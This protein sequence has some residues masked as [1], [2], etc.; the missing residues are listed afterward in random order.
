MAKLVSPLTGTLKSLKKQF[1]SKEKLLKSSVKVQKKRIDSKRQNAER[2]RFINY[3]KVLERPLS[4]LGR[5][6]KSV[7]K[8]LGFLEA[9][10]TF[11]SNVLMG[12]IALRLIKY[13]PQLIQFSIT[14]L[15]VG[16]FV[17]DVGG[18]ILN[19]LVTFVDYGYKAY[20]HAR[21]IVGKIGGE[22]AINQ[23]DNLSGQMNSI[24][25][26]IFIAGMLFSDFGGVGG[27]TSVAGKS[28]DAGVDVIKDTLAQEAGK[29]V[30]Q[31]SARTAIGP[32]AATGIV[33]GVG[34]LA[35]ALGEGAFQ[36][37]KFGKGIQGWMSGK[38]TEA[39]QDK[40]PL[41]KF[42][43]RGFYGWMQGT[44]GPAL[45]ILN[46]TGVLLDIV[47]A[48]FRYAVELIRAGFMRLNNDK[49]GLDEQR[50][51]LGKFDARVR[52]GVR[53][54]FSILSPLFSFVGM[55]GVANKLQT[56]GSLGSLYGEQAARDMGY[57]GGGKVIK[58]RKY[59]AG[60]AVSIQRTEV[61][62]VDIPR[63]EKYKTLE[64]R[65]GSLVGGTLS[66]AKVFP[67]ADDEGMMD[68]YFYMD[69]S[70]YK[71][72]SIPDLGGV[73]SLTIKSLLGD[74]VTK[75]DYNNAAS[76]L[77]SFMMLG[78]YEQN[79]A[80]YGKLS[81]SIRMKDF[82]SVLANFLMKSMNGS[83]G[84]IVSLL[85]TQVGLAPMPGDASQSEGDPCAAACDTGT[86]GGMAVS[87]DAVDKA[88][89]DL[90]SSVE[91]KDYDTMNVSRG[92]T[93]GKP[94]QMTVDWLVANARGA[95]G[96]YQQMPQYLLERVIAAGGKGSDKFTPELQDRTALKMLYSGH[97][98]SRWRSG[99]M[100][101]DDFGNRL[102]ATWR[103]LPHS[104]GGTYPDQFAG[105][106]KAHMS[107]PAF[108]TR[109][110]QIK[111]GGMGTMAKIAPGSPAANVDPCVC[112]PSVPD[113][114][115]LNMGAESVPTSVSGVVNPVPSQNIAAN[116]GGYAADT[117]LDILT[118]IGSKVVS[119][120]SGILEY[121]EKGHVA[122]MGQDANPNMPGMQDQ[123][124]VRIA[125]DKPF[126][127]KGKIVNFF[128]ATHLYELAN[129]VKNKKDIK[130]TAGTALGL[131]GV[132]NKVP[133]VHVGYVG[134]RAQN[135]FLNY[136]EVKSMLSSARQ[137][138]G[139]TLFGGTR[140]LHKGEYVIDKDSVDLF[141]GNPFFSMI[142]GV[143]NDRQRS[144]KASALMQYLSK[145]TGRKIDQRPQVIVEDSEFVAMPSPPIYVNSGSSGYSS[146]G[147]S[148]WEYHN[149]ELR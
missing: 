98:F 34:L 74:Q 130:I 38:M 56:P 81:S 60:G 76:S 9:L 131:S 40:N 119:S 84:A 36:I 28:I 85:R 41:T 96:R 44:L 53:E 111:A 42:L 49:R 139:P 73:M 4:F 25:N 103:G 140:L 121:A 6:I 47:G 46:G 63:S 93:P 51:N 61:K 27:T 14:L 12:F 137:S 123:H 149:L 16:N 147:G 113:A 5:P 1:I 133:H 43:K 78:L 87:G 144:E 110:A 19:G 129:G 77:S 124:S 70:Y 114:G 35:S 100:S 105:G 68:R 21:G 7:T 126:S 136:M 33:S 29:Q 3:E 92:A 104:S 108:M 141:G 65:P 138:G 71:I 116:K 24:M 97:G 72:S 109:L 54:H 48:P 89:L 106:N 23:L 128:Y 67:G 57:N 32:L 101:D 143:E 45:W 13:L 148:D 26:S 17:I 107:R 82:N 135:S 86:S 115:N 117:G 15:K 2:E 69:D 79:N 122:Q 145:Y 58:V 134:D 55:K 62:E 88:I 146:G 83:F 8:R 99:Q 90:I 59:A 132:A 52:D 142:N 31:Q 118:P 80:A 95:I 39:S 18:K 11:I 50:K 64:L 91:A 102:S 75:D 127:Y 30:V 112:D 66:F 125:L 20:D 94:T 10:K 37:K 120:V 22:D